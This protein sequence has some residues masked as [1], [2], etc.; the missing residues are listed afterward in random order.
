MTLQVDAAELNAPA[1]Q[2]QLVIDLL[3]DSEISD[4]DDDEEEFP[5][6]IAD[7]YVAY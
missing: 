6:T 7:M 5:E 1:Q 4:S 3:S 2:Q